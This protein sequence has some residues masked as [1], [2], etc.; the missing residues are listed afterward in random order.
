MCTRE[1]LEF[2]K[3]SLMGDS[4][5]GSRR[6]WTVK[7]VFIRFQKR[8]TVLETGLEAIHVTL[9]QRIWLY[10]VHAPKLCEDEFKAIV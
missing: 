3:Q 6:M 2:F 8:R 5:G 10:F 9:W 1:A 7:S 4:G